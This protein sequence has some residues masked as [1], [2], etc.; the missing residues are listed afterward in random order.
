MVENPGSELMAAGYPSD[1]FRETSPLGCA[2]L[3]L[4]AIERSLRTVQRDFSRINALLQVHRDTMDDTVVTQMMAGYELVDKTLADGIDLFAYGNSN[5][6]LELNT[7]VLCA[8]GEQERR[9]FLP[10]VRAT[11][12][13]FYGEH[14]AGFG[15][16]SEWYRDHRGESAWQRAAGVYVRGLSEPQLFIEGNHRTGALIMSHILARSGQPPFVLSVDN[17]VEYFDPSSVI[18][19]TRKSTFAL[20]FQLPKIKRRFAKFLEAKSDPGYLL[21]GMRVAEPAKTKAKEKKKSGSNEKPMRT[22]E[23]VCQRRS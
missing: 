16:I 22:H 17:A 9:A 10:H 21:G 13:K 11:E 6:L 4:P 20:L 3:D 15:A 14:G 2:R 18:K 8:G 5:L 12:V 19:A 7:R 23:P 1:R